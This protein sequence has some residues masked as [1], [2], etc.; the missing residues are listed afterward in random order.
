MSLARAASTAAFSP[1]GT[2][3][4][5]LFSSMPRPLKVYA[6]CSIRSTIPWKDSA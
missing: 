1:S 2:G 4:S 3:T 6:L 5:R